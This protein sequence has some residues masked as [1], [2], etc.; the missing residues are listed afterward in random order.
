MSSRRTWELVGF[1]SL[2][3][4]ATAWAGDPSRTVGLDD[5]ALR[6]G[7]ENLPTGAL[8]IVGHCEADAGSPGNPAFYPDQTLSDFLGKTFFQMSGAAGVSGHATTVGKDF[9]GL[10]G[11]SIAP[12][13]TTIY[14]YSAAGW[15]TGNYLKVDQAGTVPPAMP[16]LGLKVANHSWIGTFGNLNDDNETLRRADFAIVRD[17]MVVAYGVAHAGNAQL[18]IFTASYNGIAVGVDNGNHQSA[19]SASGY[20]GPGRQK[21][22]IVAPGNL[23]SFTT[24]IVS[25]GAALMLETAASLGPG[26]ENASRSEVIKAV[27]LAGA[28]H[29]PGWTNNPFTIGILRGI[30]TKPLDDVYGADLLNVNRSHLILT[31]G[32]HEGTTAPPGGDPVNFAGWDLAQ[33]DPGQSLYHRVHLPADAGEVS[34]LITWHRHV[35]VPFGSTNWS[36]A[37]FELHLWRVDEQGDLQPLTGDPGLG[38]WQVGNV[39]SRS[40]I[41]NIEHLYV[42]DVLAGE[43]AIE[44]RRTDGLAA[45]P[46]WDVALAWLFPEPPADPAD[47]NGDGA[48]DVLDLIAVVL[49][50]GPCP[51]CAEDVN[52]DGFVDVLDLIEV[53]LNWE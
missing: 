24:P 4:G 37:N 48:V 12:G 5:L 19:D 35:V 53:V 3:L 34:V 10:N 45:E 49:A 6:I 27:L 36:T 40:S 44:V 38:Y 51:G 43:Y 42:Q 47:V 11:T 2:A 32:E 23:T 22:E 20:D 50:W 18:P 31:G 33:V 46:D 17:D 15:V 14:S 30:A 26:N 28:L 39:V 13:I 25:G 52:G 8:V 16:P 41:D 7:A 21:P 29:R 1:A 9:Y